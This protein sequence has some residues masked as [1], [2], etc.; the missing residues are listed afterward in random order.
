MA[1]K[2]E[3]DNNLSNALKSIVEDK[4]LK[5]ERK[6][7]EPFDQS[8][9]LK[10]TKSMRDKLERISQEESSQVSDII[11]RALVSFLRNYN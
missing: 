4:H 10:V 7:K 2:K 1:I 11:R 9:S 6:K 3:E 5:E 8:L